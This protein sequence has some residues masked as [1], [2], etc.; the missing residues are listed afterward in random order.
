MARRNVKDPST[1]SDKLSP[2]ENKGQKKTVAF[3]RLMD[4]PWVLVT[5]EYRGTTDLEQIMKAQAL[6]DNLPSLGFLSTRGGGDPLYA[7]SSDP[8]Y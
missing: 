2:K 7:C 3:D 1:D 4:S 6:C 5:G 8:F